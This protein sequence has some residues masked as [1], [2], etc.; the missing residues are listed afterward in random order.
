MMSLGA[1]PLPT[2][3]LQTAQV[4]LLKPLWMGSQQ[5]LKGCCRLQCR[6]DHKP[7]FDLRPDLRKGILSCAPRPGSRS[8]PWPLS[9]VKILGRRIPTHPRLACACR[10]VAC[11]HRYRDGLMPNRALKRREKWKGDTYPTDSA[12]APT[13]RPPAT[14]DEAAIDHCW[15]R[16][17]GRLPTTARSERILFFVF[18]LQQ[19]Q[20]L[21][22]WSLEPCPQTLNGLR[23]RGHPGER[24]AQ[25]PAHRSDLY[26]DLWRRGHP[27]RR[28][29]EPA[30]P[31]FRWP[32]QSLR[33]VADADLRIH[34]TCRA[35]GERS[36]S[37][38]ELPDSDAEPVA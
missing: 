38:P 26:R 29:P 12:I 4:P 14:S 37:P 20:A 3:L 19:H 36:R 22:H 21:L 27:H 15:A 10:D 5:V 11:L 31:V 18:P 1:F 16:S 25:Y 28:Y 32:A 35:G 34:P 6:F 9:G 33:I 2:T 8:L 13:V 17:G 24:I 23:S 7:A 30:S